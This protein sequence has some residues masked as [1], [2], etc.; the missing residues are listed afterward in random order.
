M[1]LTADI[2]VALVDLALREH[3]LAVIE[4]DQTMRIQGVSQ[5]CEHYFVEAPQIGQLIDECLV[6]MVGI[7]F[8]DTL[9]LPLVQI[10]DRLPMSIETMRE[11]NVLYVVLS[12]A[13]VALNQQQSMQQIANDNELLALEKQRLLDELQRKT[14]SL[15]QASRLQNAFLAGVA[16]EFRSPLVTVSGYAKLVGQSLRDQSLRDHS[17][18]VPA[19]A[20]L[21]DMQQWVNGIGRSSAHLL[22]LIENLLDHGKGENE[23]LS[24]N[25]GVVDIS[26]LMHDVSLSLAP[27][28]S[29]KGLAL[30]MVLNG[31]SEPSECWVV[32]DQSRLNQCL[33]NIVGNAIKYTDHGSVDLEIEFA[34]EQ[35]TISVQDSGIGMTPDELSMI[36]EPFWQA[37]HSQQPGTGLGFTITAGIVE[38]MG[39]TIELA[40]KIGQGTCV[41]LTIPAAKVEQVT[42]AGQAD[43]STLSAPC[44]LL[45]VEDDDDIAVLM[46]VMLQQAGFTVSH[47]Q[48]G[49]KALALAKKDHVDLVLMDVVMPRLSGFETADSMRKAGVKAPIILMSASQQEFNHYSGDLPSFDAYL[50]KPVDVQNVIKLSNELLS[51]SS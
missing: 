26:A 14:T 50:L 8:D 21:Q 43:V 31:Q 7:K 23:A 22:G 34:D 19:S 1:E 3:K 33:I 20:A 10:A 32:T 30:N 38:L 16:H 46:T 18:L 39:G 27:Q 28:A 40:S 17:K 48:D 51:S 42:V 45:L 47:A 15:E 13:S 6:A 49:Q 37:N 11:N 35:L 44:T 2:S 25:L 36:G 24:L 12:D 5:N 9:R 4:L 29:A 41:T